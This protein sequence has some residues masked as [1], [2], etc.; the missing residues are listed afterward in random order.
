M[1]VPANTADRGGPGAHGHL[2][3]PQSRTT[4]LLSGRGAR[5]SPLSRKTEARLRIKN[6][7]IAPTV[8]RALGVNPYSADT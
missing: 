8:A 5:R 4:L 6:V 1:I 2:G 7:D 3:L